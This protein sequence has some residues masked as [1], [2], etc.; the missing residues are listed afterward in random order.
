MQS[1]SGSDGETATAQGGSQS[2]GAPA[3]RREGYSDVPVDQVSA[4]DLDGSTV[5]GVQGDQVSE[6]GDLTL[7][8]DDAQTI[9]VD[10]GGMMGVGERRVEVPFSDLMVLKGDDNGDIRVYVNAS[11]ENL[12]NYPEAQ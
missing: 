11:E 10:V 4:S 7:G 5:Y 6:I 8:S 1:A 9:I 2:Q 3:V 12:S